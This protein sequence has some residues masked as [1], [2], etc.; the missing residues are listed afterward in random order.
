MKINIRKTDQHILFLEM[1]LLL[2]LCSC[3]DEIMV[4][5]PAK[6]YDKWVPLQVSGATAGSGIDI[7]SRADDHT[8]L[9]SGSIGLFIKENIEN[10]YGAVSNQ[11]FTYATPFWQTNKQILLGNQAAIL[12][13]YYPYNSK[14][15]NPVILHAQRYNIENDFHYINFQANNQTAPITL[16]LSRVYSRLVFNFKA[17]SDYLGQGYVTVIRLDGDGVIAAATLDMLDETVLPPSKNMRDILVPITNSN[18]VEIN[19][20]TTHCTSSIIGIADCLMIPRLLNGIINL[21]ITVDG[22][23][24]TGKISAE[25]LCGISKILNEGVKYEIN[26]SIGEPKELS[27]Q[28]IKTTDWDKQPAWDEDVTFKPIP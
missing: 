7:Q 23:K 5:Q 2:L 10:R 14:K 26:I 13:A 3:T 22:K 27:I 17:D 16:N 19:G 15:T 28:T 24:K 4:T 1:T 18:L 12:A 6:V 11:E 25:Q 8:V 21:T 20:F 9:N